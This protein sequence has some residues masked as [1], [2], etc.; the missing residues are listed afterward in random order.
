MEQHYTEIDKCL[1]CF[2]IERLALFPER[3]KK[4]EVALLQKLTL[5]LD[6]G[7]RPGWIN[8]SQLCTV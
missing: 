7:L 8:L 2:N 6:L 5:W 4:Q 1:Q 3:G